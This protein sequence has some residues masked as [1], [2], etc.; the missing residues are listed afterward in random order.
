MPF[1]QAGINPAEACSDRWRHIHKRLATGE[2]PR[3]Y[4]RERHAAWLKRRRIKPPPSPDAPILSGLTTRTDPAANRLKT[5]GTGAAPLANSSSFPAIRSS[6]VR[7]PSATRRLRYRAVA[8]VG[9]VVRVTLGPHPAVARAA[10]A[11]VSHAAG[12]DDPFALFIAEHRIGSA[13][14]RRGS[15]RDPSGASRRCASVSP[16]GAMGLM[17]FMPET[18]SR[19]RFRYGL[20]TDPFDTHD[21]IVA[22][23]APRVARSVRQPRLLGCLQCR[24]GAL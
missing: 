16:K 8:C 24:T 12:I 6:L 7:R 17:Q 10:S 9:I 11:T 13:F 22:G 19:L 15:R 2:E 4:L 23:T 5:R 1:E 21:N 3:L 18:W 20:G 14:Q